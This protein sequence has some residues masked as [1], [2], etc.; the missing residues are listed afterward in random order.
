MTSGTDLA[1]EKIRR[2]TEHLKRLVKVDASVQYLSC[3]VQCQLLIFL[4]FQ[5]CSKYSLLVEAKC[6]FSQ[7]LFRFED[8]PSIPYWWKLSVLCSRRLPEKNGH[9]FQNGQLWLLEK[10]QVCLSKQEDVENLYI[11]I[12]EPVL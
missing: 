2:E 11:H 9:L 10:V 5:V 4:E 7:V 3:H 6:Y 1:G 12:L 8:Y